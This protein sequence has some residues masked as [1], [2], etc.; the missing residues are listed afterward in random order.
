MSTD[1]G[2]VDSLTAC[3]F[4]RHPHAAMLGLVVGVRVFL[5]SV[6]A[7]FVAFASGAS[8]AQV[9]VFAVG[10]KLRVAD[11]VSYQSYRDK[12]S[13]LMDRSYPNRDSL[14]QAGVDDVA[15][16]LRPADPGAPARALVVFPEDV[17][18]VPVLIGSR[19]AVART[20]TSAQGAFL[21][22]FGP[23]GPVTAHYAQKF[24]GQPFVRFL[25]LGL[26]DTLYRSFYETFRDLARKYGVYIAATMNAA[27]ARRVEAADDPALVAQLRDPDEPQRSY[28]YEATSPHVTNST[29]V[30][31]P[32]GEVIVPDGEGGALQSP[33]Q[34]GGVILPSAQ[35][36]YLTQPEQ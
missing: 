26:T 2:G 5:A 14:V 15:S 22:L 28:A 30:F 17:G 21:Q 1:M 3:P 6:L 24:P 18:L 9:R 25:F 12:M 35:K 19:G 8:A 20:Q 7:A 4:T 34:T 11:G 23:Y 33:S 27:P 31:V 36:A 10:N 29:Y 32:D 13:A 16:H